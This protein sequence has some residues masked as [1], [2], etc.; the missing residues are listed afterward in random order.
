MTI[1]KSKRDGKLYILSK[2]SPPKYTGSWI[3]CAEYCFH[4]GQIS[5]WKT[6]PDYKRND[7]YIVREV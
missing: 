3:E 2:H 7:F 4:R 5:P 1:Y 6:I